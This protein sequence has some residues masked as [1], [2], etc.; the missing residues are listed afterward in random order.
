MGVFVRVFGVLLLVLPGM[1]VAQ[2]ATYSKIDESTA[3][4][5][6]SNGGVGWGSCVS[7]AGGVSTG[8]ATVSSSPFITRPSVDGASRDFNI[9]GSAYKNGLWWYKVGTN[10]QASHFRMD[11]WLNAASS[12]QFAQ[13][14][15]FD[16]FQ[17]N[18]QI[19]Q[20]STG[21]EFMFGTQCN[22]AAGV[23]DVWDAGNHKW[24]HTGVSCSRFK[25]DVWYH[26]TLNFHRSAKDNFQ[27][28]DSLSIV[29]FDSQARM[30]SNRTYQWNVTVPS[31]PLPTGWGE[32]MGLQ[33]Q[34]DIANTGANM[35]EY[36]D[37]VTLTAW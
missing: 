5:D 20:F 37:G 31:G 24:L 13:A 36:V 15:E 8:T 34:M 14:L 23:W 27:H 11:F 35:T 9:N 16:V 1:A 30:V 3:V 17:F 32:D 18:K 29:Q 2:M 33:F 25:S 19:T 7:C 26:L 21:T 12:T 22:Y 28:Y 4:D 10:D 6:G